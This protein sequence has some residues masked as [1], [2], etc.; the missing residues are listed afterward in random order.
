MVAVVGEVG[1]VV[2]AVLHDPPDLMQLPEHHAAVQLRVL[3][4]SSAW[5]T[6]SVLLAEAALL[7]RPI[8]HTR[9]SPAGWLPRSSSAASILECPQF[10]DR[11]VEVGL[12]RMLLSVT[13]N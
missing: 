5:Q 2:G 9:P 4:W 8:P 11:P 1:V 12:A 6:G 13:Q 3:A 7:Q 10:G